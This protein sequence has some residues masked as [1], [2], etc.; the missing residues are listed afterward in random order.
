M[1][2]MIADPRWRAEM[3]K[4]LPG[5]CLLYLPHHMTLELATFH[6]ELVEH[7]GD[8]DQRFLEVLGFRG[9]A[10]ST[11][12]SLALP[13]WGAL[14]HP[15]RYPFIIPIADTQ[16]QAK[17]NIQNI[18]EELENNDL[19]T[20][21]YGPQENRGD[22]QKEDMTL[23]SGVR[24]LARSRGQKVRG[25]RHGRHRPSLVPVD[26][27]EDG[28]WV[29]SKTNR[30]ETERWFK[31]EVVPAV[32]EKTGR[33]L[34]I[35][36]LLH[37]DALMAR[38]EKTGHFKTLK[39]PLIDG[40]GNVT[41]PAKYPDKQ[42]LDTQRALAGNSGW[43]REYMLKVVPEEGQEVLEE[44]IRYYDRL[45]GQET[46]EGTGIDLAIS[47]SQTADYTAMVSGTIAR[48][49]DKPQIFIHARPVEARLSFHETIE[50][51]KAIAHG[52]GAF[53]RFFVED[54]AY[55]RAAI[56]EMN[57]AGLNATSMKVSTDKRARLRGIAHY[58][59]D[60]TVQFAREGCEDLL[61]QLTHFGVEEHDDLVDA[62]V[63]LVY[64]LIDA[65]A[66][67]PRVIEL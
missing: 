21:D 3:R 57:R 30:D 18:Q 16:L 15:D 7:L 61:V 39:Y 34:L 33:I 59:Q 66:Q 65:G 52:K 35:G 1:G 23:A 6:A 4:T 64:G 26:D 12:A 67:E 14:E 2:E 11:F 49:D 25:L 56:E 37:T 24:I 31:T 9:S 41:W 38:I 45:P 44:W 10:K 19:I 60:G 58:I 53:H 54:V 43:S 13:L 62:F 55:Q 46:A 48:V 5:F 27:P 32:D 50:Q 22:W 36:N 17:T 29:R 40:K 8:H 63:H 47:K 28:K 20:N 42:T 51:A